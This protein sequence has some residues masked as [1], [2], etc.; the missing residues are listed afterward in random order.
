MLDHELE[1]LRMAR[2]HQDMIIQQLRSEEHETADSN[3]QVNIVITIPYSPTPSG[4]ANAACTVHM[5]DNICIAAV[6]LTVKL[7]VRGFRSVKVFLE[8]LDRLPVSGRL[9]NPETAVQMVRKGH[10]LDKSHT[11]QACMHSAL[12]TLLHHAYYAHHIT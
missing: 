9:Q 5:L 4:R 7:I 3:V 6:F 11:T 8:K 12:C 1:T 2:S 10:A